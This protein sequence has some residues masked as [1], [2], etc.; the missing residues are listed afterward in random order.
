MYRNAWI[1]IV[2]ACA[3]DPAWAVRVIEQPEGA[4]E[5]ALGGVS[6]PA[7]ATGS[8]SFRPCADCNPTSLRVSNATRYFVNG[9][10]VPLEGLLRNVEQLQ[11]TDGDWDSILL[12]VYYDRAS[13]RV[14]RIALLR[15]VATGQAN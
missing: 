10:A 2:L 4:Y 11:Q 13:H 7:G 8:V 5:L 12:T 14:N 15:P 1:L 9:T 6:L 3:L